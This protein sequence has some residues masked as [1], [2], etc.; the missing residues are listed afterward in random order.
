MK[1]SR[2]IALWDNACDEKKEIKAKQFLFESKRKLAI[3]YV[4]FTIIELVVQQSRLMFYFAAGWSFLWKPIKL[5][6]FH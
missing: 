4:L 5:I 2:A 6:I 3:T 1:S